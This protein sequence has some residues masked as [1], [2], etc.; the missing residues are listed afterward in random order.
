MLKELVNI[1]LIG[2][3]VKHNY[4]SILPIKKSCGMKKN[5]KSQTCVFA[6]KIQIKFSLS[7]KVSLV[8]YSQK[9]HFHIIK[10][11]DNT[12]SKF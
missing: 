12:I 6:D 11:C 9:Q 5:A 7:G 8:D 2:Y 3:L 1:S 4:A 10:L